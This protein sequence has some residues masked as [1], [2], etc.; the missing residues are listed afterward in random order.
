MRRAP[1]FSLLEVLVALAITG[2]CLALVTMSM[3]TVFRA[4]SRAIEHLE[5]MQTMT[6]TQ[7]RIRSYLQSAYLSPYLA[8]QLH[9]EFEAKDSDNMS[10]PYD[11][12]TFATL[13]V[14]THRMDSHEP[15]LSDVTLFTL[16][17]PPLE[18]P[19]G[20]AQCRRLRI[21]VGGEIND[22][23]EV[24]GGSVYTLADHVTSFLLEYLDQDGDWKGE[25]DVIDHNNNLPCAI[26]VTLGLRTENLEERLDIMVVPMEMTG[27]PCRWDE[28][29]VFER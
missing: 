16:E 24:E 8:N 5:L 4:N 15:D 22:R 19:A 23:F 21:R 17:E 9:T 10:H 20:K 13:A 6:E 7:E 29:K 27:L 14:T 3:G 18:T 28:G 1:G 25:W 26:R 11:S 12:I 2:L